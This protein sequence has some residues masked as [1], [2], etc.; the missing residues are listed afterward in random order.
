MKRIVSGLC[1]LLSLFFSAVA[2]TV[3]RQCT[4]WTPVL[5]EAPAGAAED[6]CRL[7]DAVCAGDLQQVRR[8]LAL[9]EK[10]EETRDPAGVVGPMVWQRY[11]DSLDYELV[12]DLYPTDTGLAQNVKLIH[13]EL[14]TATRDLGQRARLLL[15]QTVENAENV[16]QLYDASNSYRQDLVTGVL[17]EAARQ[18]LEEDVRYTYEVFPVHMTHE[19]GQWQITADREFWSAVSGGV[20]ETG[21]VLDHFDMYMTNVTSEALEGIL[22]IDKVYWLQEEDPVAPEPDPEKYGITT[23]PGDL[24][25]VIGNARKLLKDRDLIFR[26]DVSLAPDSTVTWYQDET[27]LSITWQQNDGAAI[28]TCAETVIAHPSQF[29]R[30]L[31]G[32]EFGSG[33]LNLATQMAADVNA[34]TASNGDFYGYRGY[35]NLVYNGEVKMAENRYLDTCYVDENGDL[36]FRD[37]NTVYKKQDVQAFVTE[38]NIRFSLAFGPIL[39]EDGKVVAKH[40]YAIG[41]TERPYSRAALCQIGPLHYMFVTVNRRGRDVTQFARYLQEMGIPRA[42]AL[43]GG[44][45]STIVMNDQLMNPVDYGGQ[46][47]TSDILY[48]ATAV[49]DGG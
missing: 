34:V 40:H 38:Q 17:E 43:D 25:P 5:V 45:T 20:S 44:Q 7:M 29:R 33:Q 13:L 11:V 36:L 22:A 41:E 19:D 26:T 4:D 2:V 12:G 39:V 48:F 27:I 49:P 28:Y 9:E 32:G 46:R 31:S 37:L 1:I 42:Y 15:Q 6:V 30:F 10:P 21:A 35:G 8:L 16:S 3:A 23:D 18:A 24:E 47:Q 14:P